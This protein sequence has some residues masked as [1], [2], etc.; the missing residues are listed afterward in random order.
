MEDGG[1][2]VSRDAM[3][4]EEDPTCHVTAQALPSSPQ[5]STN[6]DVGSDAVLDNVAQQKGQ[7]FG[8]S[9]RHHDVPLVSRDSLHA[10]EDPSSHATAHA[11]PSSPRAF[12]NYDV[13]SG[14]VL[15]DGPQQKERKFGS[16]P[17]HDDV[18][19]ISR[20]AL[21]AEED[22]TSCHCAGPTFKS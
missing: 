20:D 12:T 11:I 22:P 8:S 2:S 4:A 1:A 9:S 7:K 21:H 14:A 18:A 13:G 19:S 15:D 6:H 3:H 16:S 5:E 10:E 17:R